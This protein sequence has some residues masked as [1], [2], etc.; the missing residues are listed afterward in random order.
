MNNRWMCKKYG[1]NW[2]KPS[3]DESKTVRKKCVRCKKKVYY[4]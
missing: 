2:E 4:K 1:H 3:G